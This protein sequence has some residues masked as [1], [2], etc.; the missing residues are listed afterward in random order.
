MNK[1]WLDVETTGLYSNKHDIVQLACIP[2]INGVKQKPFNEFCQPANWVAIQQE[3]V[4]THGITVEQMRTFQTPE[5]MINKFIDYIRQ[6][7]CQ[8]TISGYNVSFDR[9]FVSQF[10]AKQGRS[11]E[12]FKLFTLGVHCTFARAKKVKKELGTHNLKLETLADHFGI[13]IDA[14]DALSD[15]EA[16][17]DVDR[18]IA[19][20]LGEDEVQAVSTVTIG[21]EDFLEPAQLHVHSSYGPNSVCRVEDWAKWCAE[22]NTPGFSVVDHGLAASFHDITNLKTD[23]VQGVPGVGLWLSLDNTMY[24]FNAW[25]I[26]TEGYFNLMKLASVGWGSQQIVDGNHMPVLLEHN[27]DK[28]GGIVVSFGDAYDS[29][30]Q[31]LTTHSNDEIDAVAERFI[32]IFGA[33]NI[34]LEMIPIDILYRFTQKIGFQPIARN[35]LIPDGN[36]GKSFNLLM[37][38]LSKKYSLRVIPTTAA[39][40][41]LPEDKMVQDCV[42]KNAYDSGKYFHES[43]IIKKSNE[44]YA[45]LKAHL[46][47]DFTESIFRDMIKN[48]HDIVDL[49]SNIDIKFDYHLPTVDIPSNIADKIDDYKTQCFMYMMEKIKEHGRWREDPEYKER[50]EKEID[51]IM[52]NNTISFVP[53]FLLYE[54][55]CSYARSVGIFLGEGRGSAGGSLLSYY[56]KIIQIDPIEANLPFER[57]LSHARIHGGSFPDIDGDFS[58]RPPLIKYLMDKYGLGFAQITT[59]QRM[60][61]KNAIKDAMS[62][63]YGRNRN[64]FEIKAICDTIPDSPQG[65]EEVD[66]LFGFT[67]KEGVYHEGQVEVNEMLSNFFDNYPE[68]KD[69]VSKLIGTTRGYGRHASA[70]VISSLD[71]AS[72]RVPTMLMEDEYLGMV[73]VTQYAAK[74]VEAC[75][76][77]K[78][79]ILKVTSLETV[80]QAVKLIKDST[81]IDYMEE[82]DKGVALIYR[83]PDDL[84][85]YD[86]FYRKKTDSV[87]QFNTEI[88]K[89]HMKQFK[90]E[91]RE[92]LSAMT[93]V[94]RPGAMD[95]PFKLPAAVKV[96]YDDGTIEYHDKKDY[97]KWLKR[98]K[99][100][101]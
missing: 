6:F 3:A 80:A 23:G 60:K 70:Y 91:C 11:I 89:A 84:N 26:S 57:F 8:F 78:A 41:I 24:S 74:S 32:D 20:L 52:N 1:L 59:I 30:G 34:V 44:I 22:N 69:M 31:M 39:H 45:T 72:S 100:Q 90:P 87:F 97:N 82:D 9:S 50:F 5:Q 12:F 61:T 27:L 2:V 4:N 81:G 85:V 79:D 35:D 68:V 63:L 19:A 17:M 10:F 29:L 96:T 53:Y 46:G 65:V 93:A 94:L 101:Q 25:A 99:N 95:A 77:I 67:D 88:S 64:D 86:D 37:W 48:T 66:F 7:N 33:E 55:M 62:A 49:A 16:T 73:P 75:G 56:L 54:D 42:S 38:R 15:I 18:Q 36:L 76:L 47:D 83:L 28:L 21:D 51:V 13:T 40:F 43:Y 58:N 98:L 71:L 92:D 14:H